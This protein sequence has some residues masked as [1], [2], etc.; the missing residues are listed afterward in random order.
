M[1]STYRS[2]A[3]YFKEFFF[4]YTKQ[5]LKRTGGFIREFYHENKKIHF[6]INKAFLIQR[7][8]LINFVEDNVTW[9]IMPGGGY[10]AYMV[11]REPERRFYYTGGV[12]GTRINVDLPKDRFLMELERIEPDILK[13]RVKSCLDHSDVFLNDPFFLKS[14]ITYYVEGKPVY[15]YDKRMKSIH[16]KSKN[17][18][19]ELRSYFDL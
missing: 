6:T 9:L 13:D 5:D 19:D 4:D 11:E 7:I 15:Y 14:F 3:M 18:I 2:F 8:Y 12:L 1:G 10:S 17:E 16:S